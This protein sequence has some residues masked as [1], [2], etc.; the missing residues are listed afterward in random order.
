M[1]FLLKNLGKGDFGCT[2]VAENNISA[3][4]PTCILGREIR[5]KSG[6][7]AVLHRKSRY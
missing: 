3:L 4:Y 2:F 5:L 1:F 6:C 7:E